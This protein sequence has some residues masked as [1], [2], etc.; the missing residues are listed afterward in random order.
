MNRVELVKQELKGYIDDEKAAFLPRF[1]KAFKGGYGEGDQ[2]LGIVVPL[3]RKVARKYYKKIS[4]EEIESL[5]KEPVH[6]YRLTALLMLVNKFEKATDEPERKAI[7]DTYLNNLESVNNWD[8]VDLSAPNILGAF[9]FDKDKSILYKMART[10]DLWKQRI[11]ILSTF[12]FIKQG[13]YDD[14]LKITEIL[15]THVHDLIQKA[16]GWML[17]EIGKRDFRVEYDFLKLNY[18]IMPRTMLRY[19]IERFESEL[20]QKFLKGLI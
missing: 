9:L 18:R 12:Y 15:L 20:R 4:L 10:P 13:R 19:A 7:V 8:L 2:F 5:L 6:E 3:Q 1:F 14:T 16:V 17:R 11:A